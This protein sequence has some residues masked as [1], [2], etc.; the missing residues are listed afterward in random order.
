[1]LNRSG[2]EKALAERAGCAPDDPRSLP[3]A[4]VALL[5]ID[6]DRFKPVND[7]HGHAVGDQLLQQFARRLRHLVRP[8]DLIARLGGDEFVIVLD[9]LHEEANAMPVAD[10]V[11]AAAEQPF[12]VSPLPP[13]HIGASIGIAFWRPCGPVS[14]DGWPQALKRADAMLY[15][16]KA[17][18]RGRA[19]ATEA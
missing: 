16:A 9:G 6:L 8:T 13:L 11:V 10:K 19:M 4:L 2:F 17:A 18:G 3:E 5:Y 7:E 12:D 1:V 14:G 15:R